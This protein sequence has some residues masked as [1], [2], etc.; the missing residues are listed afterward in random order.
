MHWCCQA[1]GQSE[2]QWKIAGWQLFFE[3]ALQPLPALIVLAMRAAAMATGM[4]DK[5]LLVT[6]RTHQR[7]ACGAARFHRP[8][9]V[10]LAGQRISGRWLGNRP[11]RFG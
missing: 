8:Q 1:S 6:V 3:L 11:Q 4:R 10:K 7:A 5:V 9:R 2:S